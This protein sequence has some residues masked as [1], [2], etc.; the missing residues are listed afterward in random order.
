ML[1]IAIGIIM[2][3]AM[4][5]LRIAIA[6]TMRIIHTGINASDHCAMYALTNAPITAL[7]AADK[8]KTKYT[9]TDRP[10]ADK[11]KSEKRPDVTNVINARS[12]TIAISGM[13]INAMDR[14]TQNPM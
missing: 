11:A 14:E 3:I 5:A 6:C 9:P 7:I 13:K 4:D 10:E 2:K 8:N 1:S 12:S